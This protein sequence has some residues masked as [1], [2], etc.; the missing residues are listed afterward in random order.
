MNK[1]GVGTSTTNFKTDYE[2]K[3]LQC[4]NNSFLK[5]NVI[6]LNKV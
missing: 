1:V 2:T 6:T 5:Q 3:M 4:K